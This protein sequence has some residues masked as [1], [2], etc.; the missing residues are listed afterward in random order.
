MEKSP[1]SLYPKPS[2]QPRKPVAQP[3]PKFGGVV[4][5]FSN[6]VGYI[7]SNRMV[8]LM[9]SDGIGM[10]L[11]RTAMAFSKRGVDDGR[12]TFLREFTGLIGNVLI[13]GWFGYGM[14]KLLGNRVN[15]YNPHG[16]PLDAHIHANNLEAFSK[17]YHRALAE[18]QDPEK[19]RSTFID[20]FMESLKSN[21]R[22]FILP[23]QLE[24]IFRVQDETQ[25]TKLLK[26]LLGKFF[27]E[28]QVDSHLKTLQGKTIQEK[29]QYLHPILEPLSGKLSKSSRTKLGEF[30]KPKKDL[31]PV[32]IQE[33]GHDAGTL[34]LQEQAEARIKQAEG[35]HGSDYAEKLKTDSAFRR[36]EVS[37][38]RLSLYNDTKEA[39]KAFV[40]KVDEKALSLGITGTVDLMDLESGSAKKSL[41]SS[42]QSRKNTLKELKYFLEH[43]VDRATSEV[44]SGWKS[45]KEA[46]SGLSKEHIKAQAVEERLFHTS[47]S[48]FLGQLLPKTEDGLVS[49]AV[50]HK[51]AL[52]AVPI[53]LSILSAGAFT[54]YNQYITTQ[55]HGGKMFFPGEGNPD[56]NP[57]G[58]TG[59]PLI[60]PAQTSPLKHNFRPTMGFQQ[61]GSGNGGILA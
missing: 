44:E 15:G 19:A 29:N 11:P 22:Q 9:A 17:L 52:T 55:K 33:L 51:K 58:T 25:Q 26:D 61:N 57:T 5:G 16:I 53:A 27:T 14:L 10:I 38:I 20:K 41:L 39:T 32:L 1:I 49:A 59:Q 45:T 2:Y 12:E 3:S 6:L 23:S 35:I 50:K 13:T 8:E 60:T 36:R 42:G 56:A 46:P 30:F 31:T 28:D 34:S 43:Y 47:R 40:Q 21:N 18:T 48:G 37:K 24:G 54:F 7:D 4:D